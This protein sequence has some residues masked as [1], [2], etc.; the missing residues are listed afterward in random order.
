MRIVLDAIGGDHAPRETVRGAVQA[1]RAC[2]CT[3][4]LVG[5]QEPILAEL[6]RYKTQGLDLQVIDAPQV[7]EMDEHPAKAVRRKTNSSHIV[8]LRMVRDGKADAF[9]S[10]GHSGASMA[11]AL[12]ILGRLPGIERPAL[13]SILP[14]LQGDTPVLLLDVGANTDC[15]PEYLLQFAQMGSIYV[16]HML[17]LENPRVALLSNGEEA[18]KGDRR[19]QEARLLLL[20]SGLNFVGNVEPKDAIINNICDVVVADGFVGNLVLKMGQATVSFATKK[21]RAELLHNLLPRLVAGLAPVVLLSLLPG[22]GRWRAGAGAL[23][24]AAGLLGA[25]LLPLA[26]VRR[27]MDYRVSGGVPLLGV[28]GV[29]VIAHGKSD[30]LAICN[31]IRRAKETVE[32]HT[33]QTIAEAMSAAREQQAVPPVPPLVPAPNMVSEGS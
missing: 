3:V 6:R 33:V 26:R 31:A 20:Q 29:V 23:L 7:I 19:V 10:A 8:G 11:G 22:A 30:A 18:S 21:V 15:K 17:G 25:G 13:G 24:G 32:S 2:G 14:R 12:L 16:R 27:K 28:K 9:V 4:L 5:P 1:A